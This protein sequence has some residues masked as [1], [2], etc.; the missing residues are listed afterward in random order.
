M[1]T[2]DAATVRYLEVNPLFTLTGADWLERA[3]RNGD[4]RTSWFGRDP[5]LENIRKDER[6]RQILKSIAARRSNSG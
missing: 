2:M 3:V 1:R 6:F 5:A 4:H